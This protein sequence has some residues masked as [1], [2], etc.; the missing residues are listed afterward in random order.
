LINGRY[1]VTEYKRIGVQGHGMSKSLVTRKK[2]VEAL[3][4]SEE[5]FR[6]IV[7][8]ASDAIISADETEKI[9][10]WNRGAEVI[11]GY[12]ADEVIG[13]EFISILPER[14]RQIHRGGFIRFITGE[15]HVIGKT[16]ELVGLKKDGS[17]FPLEL[18]LS[19]WM[20]R[21][22]NFF[23]GIIR[24]ITLRKSQEG[25]LEERRKNLERANREL[26]AINKELDSFSYAVSHDLKA[27]LRA[28]ANLSEWLVQDYGDKLDNEG[29]SQL[30]MLHHRAE[31]MQTLINGILEYSRIGRVRGDIVE[32]D[33]RELIGQAVELLQPRSG[34]HIQI[35]ADLPKIHA[36]KTRIHQLFQNLLD[37]A[38]KFMDKPKGDIRV[39]YEDAGVHW[40]FSVSDNGPGIEQRYFEKIFQLFQTLEARDKMDSTGVGLAL[41][42]KIVDLY[43][44]SIRVQSEIGKGSTFFFTLPKG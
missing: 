14:L 44:G 27:P 26:L 18:S 5:R 8:T 1:T 40:Q 31:Y 6:E 23:T 15:V 39:G 10:S 28:I 30:E 4:V 41:V 16:V 17:E 37:N 29:K 38:I 32:I 33:L 35:P 3:R 13:K 19:N 43:G 7:E 11:F 25:L 9:V 12:V 22:G 20:V 24:D 2:T 21:E 42:K 34:I 36:E